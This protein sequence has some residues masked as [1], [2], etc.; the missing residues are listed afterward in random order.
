MRAPAYAY[1]IQH[2]L[3]PGNEG[4]EQLS[5]ESFS[6]NISRNFINIDIFTGSFAIYF[7]HLLS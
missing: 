5:I 4:Y 2:M 6:I 1:S 3:K 7:C